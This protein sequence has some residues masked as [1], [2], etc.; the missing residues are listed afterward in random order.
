MP[1]QQM[2]QF[3]AEPLKN[4]ELPSPGIG[5]LNLKDLEFEQEVN[6]SPYMLNMMY[7]NGAFGKRYGQ[8]IYLD[9]ADTIYAMTTYFD[10][11]F[12]HAGTKIYKFAE[13]GTPTE[14][15]SGFPEIR[16]LF[17]TYAQDLYYLISTGFYK[18]NGT[19][20]NV[21]DYYAPEVLINCRAD[22]SHSDPLD[23]FNILGTKFTYVYNA[24]GTSTNY[25]VGKYDEG[26]DLIDWS[27]TS[28]FVVELDGDVLTQGTDYSVNT[29]DKKIVFTTA[30]LSGEL[31]LLV[32]MPMVATAFND[33]KAQLLR[34][35]AYET[36][37]GANNSRLFLA[38][39]GLSK[40]FYSESFDISFFPENN[41]GVLGN[42]EEDIVG[43]GRQY[44]VLIV[45][46]PREI[47]A[48]YS[49][50]ETTATTLAE[51]KIGEEGF[52]SKLVNPRIGCDAP[53]S[54]QLINNLLTWFNSKEGICTL[55]STNIQDERNV[56]TISRNIER[57]NAMGTMG[58][59]D[60]DEDP[61]NVQSA[62]FDNKYF[63]CFPT[64][65]YCYIWDYEISPYTFTSRG[66]TPPRQLDWFILDHFY[67]GEFL[68]FKKDLV[69][70]GSG[71]G[72]KDKII[73]LNNT[74]YD[75]DFDGNGQPDA[76]EAWYMTPFL[77]FDAVEYLKNIKNLYV[78][79]RGDTASL[80]DIYYYTDESQEPEQDAE[81]IMVGGKLWNHFTW[82]SFKWSMVN[83][84][85]TYRRKC[86]LKKVQMASFLFKNDEPGRDMSLTHIAMQY[87]IVKNVK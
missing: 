26:L 12:V 65:G 45:F 8:E 62:D 58:I 56:R 44:N 3:K 63:L 42:T 2:P 73:V 86:S 19:S 43:F 36:F 83:W 13:D 34:C 85:I 16:G 29:T 31:N 30:P 76:I 75:L 64:Y 87:Q 74:F 81:S 15:G 80:I 70:S 40:Y 33:E 28:E 48:I 35:K 23:D 39:N 1:I 38:R 46:K 32:T 54:I 79:C 20:F 24:D 6:Q 25:L 17:I 49:Y 68:K 9:C 66:E 55:V 11:I 71:D 4:F 60:L 50:V 14:V 52:N 67:V 61:A 10:Q 53:Y 72:F 59:L 21:L 22:G 47:Y 77:Q 84:A 57:T 27:R 5:G 18:Y 41:Y 82:G 51:D 37:G 69:Y 7:R 78:Q